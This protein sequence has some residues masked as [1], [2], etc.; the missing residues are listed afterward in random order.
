MVSSDHWLPLASDE[1]VALELS[2]PLEL[3][4]LELKLLEGIELATLLMALELVIRLELANTGTG[5]KLDTEELSAELT[6][7][8]TTDELSALLT[9]LAARLDRGVE[10]LLSAALDGGGGAADDTAAE[11]AGAAELLGCSPAPSPE[12]PPPPQAVS[13]LITLHRARLLRQ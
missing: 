4:L 2:A 9:E 13:R 10:L 1:L 5:T 11:E 12:L 6:E 3:R 8:L 7:E